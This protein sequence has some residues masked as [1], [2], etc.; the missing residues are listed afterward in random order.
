MGLFAAIGALTSGLFTKAAVGKAVLGAGASLA[1]GNIQRKQAMKDQRIAEETQFQ[2][3]RDAAS[4]AGFNPLSA[5]RA[6]ALSAYGGT[7]LPPGGAAFAAQYLGDAIGEA[8][9]K[10]ANEPIEKYNAEIRKLELEQRK[11]DIKLSRATLGGLNKPKDSG[12]LSVPLYDTSGSKLTDGN[13]NTIYV[14]AEANEVIPK[15]KLVHDQKSGATYAIINPELTES[16]L[17]E[18]A[19]G[20]AMDAAGQ[21]A[22]ETGTGLSYKGWGFSA[23]PFGLNKGMRF[24]KAS[25][26]TLAKPKLAF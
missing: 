3:M 12:P 15:Y 20:L 24:P 6:G 19:T 2:R 14:P 25:N 11:M 22:A 23:D 10:K 26:L 21:A 13:G 17:S 1:V 4:R 18:M 7:A 16:G 9:D 5:L 8:F